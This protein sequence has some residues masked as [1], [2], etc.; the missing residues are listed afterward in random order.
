MARQTM[1][2]TSTAE[3][4]APASMMSRSSLGAERSAAAM[5]RAN[6]V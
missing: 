5:R 4:P 2:F 6:N 1:S 3:S